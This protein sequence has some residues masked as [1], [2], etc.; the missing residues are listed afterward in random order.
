MALEIPHGANSN[1]SIVERVKHKNQ[2]SV[3][4]AQRQLLRLFSDSLCACS[5]PPCRTH[6]HRRAPFQSTSQTHSPSTISADETS[7]RRAIH[8]RRHF[9]RVRSGSCMFRRLRGG[10]FVV[11]RGDADTCSTNKCANY[12]RLRSPSPSK[13]AVRCVSV[14]SF[15]VAIAAEQNRQEKV[16]T[17]LVHT[18]AVATG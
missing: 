2:R 18:K 10:D 17:M 9:L 7:T 4:T 16:L 11:L 13:G 15:I 12:Q 1:E 8:R 6:K 3:R 5:F 14:A